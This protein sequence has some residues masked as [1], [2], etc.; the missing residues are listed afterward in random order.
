LAEIRASRRIVVLGWVSEAPGNHRTIQRHLGE[1][2]AQIAS[3]AIFVESDR[4]SYLAGAVRAGLPRNAILADGKNVS[5][6]A[7]ELRPM[8]GE[9]DVVLIKGRA[10][11]K[12]D[13]IA[14]SLMG[15]RVGCS[16]EFCD[17]ELRCADC[18]MLECGWGASVQ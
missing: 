18:P 2:V 1:R 9:G 10:S 14:L 5:K 7:E 3:H 16:I 13:R 4:R 15:R 8:L 12:L 17:A 11:Q 6:I